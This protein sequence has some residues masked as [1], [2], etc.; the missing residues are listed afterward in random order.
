MNPVIDTP[1]TTEWCEWPVASPFWDGTTRSC[2]RSGHG[3]HIRL[4][5]QHADAARAEVVADLYDHPDLRFS[6]MLG[7][8]IRSTMPRETD[9]P[10]RATERADSLKFAT[11]VITDLVQYYGANLPPALAGAL[12][13]LIDRLIEERLTETWGAA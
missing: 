13:P 5:W 9:H 8:W 6:R 10:E 4:C 3:R 11:A 7:D 1:P 12:D 2:G